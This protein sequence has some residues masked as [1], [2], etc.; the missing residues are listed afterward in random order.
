MFLRN[1]ENVWNWPIGKHARTITGTR[2]LRRDRIFT[3]QRP[4][5]LAIKRSYEGRVNPKLSGTNARCDDVGAKL[6]L[7]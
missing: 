1:H 4:C 5:R 7:F 2:G 6:A 3:Q